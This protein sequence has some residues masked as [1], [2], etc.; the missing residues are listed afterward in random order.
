VGS[1]LFFTADDGA[2]GTELWTSDGTPD[3][4]KMLKD[5]QPGQQ[6]SV[7]FQLTAVGSTLFFLVN[8]GDPSGGLW[9]SD[10][11]ADGTVPLKDDD[12]S[13]IADANGTAFIGGGGGLWTTD[14]TP[15]G[16]IKLK[17]FYSQAAVSFQGTL[18]FQGSTSQGLELWK[19][20]G[21]VGGTVMVKD[22]DPGPDSGYP[23]HMTPFGN[24]L[25]FA[26]NDG[27]HGIELWKSDG[28]EAGTVMIKD[29]NP[30]MRTNKPEPRN[31]DPQTFVSIGKRALF[32]ANRRG[33]GYELWRTD[34]TPTGTVM[35]RDIRHGSGGIRGSQIFVMSRLLGAGA[36]F[37]A[38]DGEHGA[39][40]WKSNGWHDGTVLV[41]DI[42]SGLASSNAPE[43]GP[44]LTTFGTDGWFPAD[45]GVHGVEPW[46]TDGTQAGTNMLKNINP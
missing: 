44:V 46:T 36:V 5:I 24:R 28:T 38:N 18:Y 1:T 13:Y 33:H 45:D 11:T 29:I 21:T 14:G 4:T 2:H 31:S 30:G 41:K 10:G 6:G 42:N 12:F 20:N 27:V 39:E 40:L 15:E 37:Y 35:V 32:V 17:D 19:S 8:F 26:A 9:K 43:V 3:G 22:I 34:G 7:P 25:L 16:T 23:Y